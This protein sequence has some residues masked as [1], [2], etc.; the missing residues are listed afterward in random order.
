MTRDAA[1]DGTLVGDDG[2]A[3]DPGD[4]AAAGDAPSPSDAG[5]GEPGGADRML[6]GLA[7][8]PNP[9]APPGAEEMAFGCPADPALRACYALDDKVTMLLDG[10]GQGNNGMLNSA[11]TAP[12]VRGL[13]LRFLDGQR[14]ALVP[15]APSLR[16]EGSTVTFEAWI[17]PT[18][19]LT[20]GNADFIVGKWT[21]GAQGYLFGSYAGSVAAYSNGGTGRRAGMLVLNTWS[22]VAAVLSASGV[23]LFINGVATGP[24]LAPLTLMANTEPLTIGNTDPAGSGLPAAQTAFYGDIDVI[25]IYARSRTPAEICADANRKWSGTACT[26]ASLVSQPI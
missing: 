4:V 16:L 23:T 11:Q 20:D 25:R 3:G 14:F 12:G 2:A 8:R 9:D 21:R 26:N 22:H 13:A 19:S 18:M 24:A 15:D 17:R 10:S 5:A 7:E 6:D 1:D